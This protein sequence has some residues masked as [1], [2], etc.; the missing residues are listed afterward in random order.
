MTQSVPFSYFIS[1]AAAHVAPKSIIFSSDL[2]LEIQANSRKK[3]KYTEAQWELSE[4][5]DLKHSGDLV[6]IYQREQ[7]VRPREGGGAY[8]T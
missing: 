2:F 5:T 8:N 1:Y 3:E 6:I 4:K 7:T